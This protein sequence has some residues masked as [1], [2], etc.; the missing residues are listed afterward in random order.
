M[1]DRMQGPI[2][3]ID[4]EISWSEYEGLLHLHA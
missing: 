3:L 4:R 2:G 1:L